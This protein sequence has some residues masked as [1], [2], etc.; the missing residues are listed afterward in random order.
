[1]AL[2][3]GSSLGENLVAAGLKNHSP[4]GVKGQS[5]CVFGYEIEGSRTK[6]VRIY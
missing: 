5:Y 1:M 4:T 3:A 2:I 6:S